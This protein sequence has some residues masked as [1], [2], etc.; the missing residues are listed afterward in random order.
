MYHEVKP[1]NPA[2]ILTRL[3]FTNR[4]IELAII[5]DSIS[6]RMTLKPDERWSKDIKLIVNTNIVK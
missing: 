5:G 4:K 3:K 6:G 2:R 1:R